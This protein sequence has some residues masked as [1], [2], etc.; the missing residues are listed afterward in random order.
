MED[1]LN[2]RQPQWKTTSMED[3]LYLE[4]TSKGENLIVRQSWWLMT[5]KEDSHKGGEPQIKMPYPSI[6]N[7]TVERKKKIEE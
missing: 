3:N 5:L 1:N 4:T 6:L 7:I 2:R